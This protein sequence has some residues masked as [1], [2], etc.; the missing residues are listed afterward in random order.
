MFL[1]YVTTT[2]VLSLRGADS[3]LLDLKGLI[4]YWKKGAG[5]YTIIPLTGRFK[6]EHED[7]E[8]L[9]PCVN[10]TK[11]GIKVRSVLRRLIKQKYDLGF[12]DGPAI[13]NHKGKL[14]TARELDEM[15]FESLSYIYSQDPS[16]FPQDF[17][18]AD[19]LA[20]SYQCLRTFRRSAA[21][22]A[23]EVK[24]SKTDTEIVDRWCSVK[25]AAG[26]R[27]NLPMHIS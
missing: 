17:Q 8:H 22:R 3:F 6:G 9:I 13:S 5:Q 11:S 10:Q 21:T 16:L 1:T 20:R 2:Y 14:F 19:D 25:N 15:L 26:K 24:I 4:K 27:P 12:R 18:S 7:S 23:I